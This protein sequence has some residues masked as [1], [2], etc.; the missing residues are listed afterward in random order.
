LLTA[1]VRVCSGAILEPFDG[2]ALSLGVNAHAGDWA[3]GGATTLHGAATGSHL[4]RRFSLRRIRG[5]KGGANRGQRKGKGDLLRFGD[6]AAQFPTAV[7]EGA[8]RGEEGPPPL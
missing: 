7:G 8:D 6:W 2:G 3:K 4:S 5:V 1:A